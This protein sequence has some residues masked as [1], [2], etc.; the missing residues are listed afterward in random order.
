M[1]KFLNGIDQC[2]QCPIEY[3]HVS[4]DYS[5]RVHEDHFQI[6]WLFGVQFLP[7]TEPVIAN[8]LL[9]N[10]IEYSNQGGV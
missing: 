9:N 4:P 3:L 2:Q 6:S 7:D 5:V 1:K 10:Y 8:N